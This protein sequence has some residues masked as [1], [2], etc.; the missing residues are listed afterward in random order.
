MWMQVKL[1]YQKACFYLSGKIKKIGRVDNK[2]AYLDN[3][4]LERARGLLFF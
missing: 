4:E 3:Y 1:H 2:D